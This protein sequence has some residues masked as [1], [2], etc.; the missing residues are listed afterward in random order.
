MDEGVVRYSME[1]RRELRVEALAKVQYPV[2]PPVAFAAKPAE[3]VRATRSLGWRASSPSAKALP[4][5]GTGAAGVWLKHEIYR[6]EAEKNP[7]RKI[8]WMQA[9]LRVARYSCTHFGRNCASLDGSRERI[10]P[11]STDS[12]R[13][14]PIARLSL[15]RS[16][17]VLRSIGSWS[18]GDRRR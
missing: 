14:Q 3:L 10:S 16:W 4:R 1:E 5:A 17:F 6:T 13:E 18:Q 8:T 2:L 9:R 15:Q 7:T 12:R 11:L